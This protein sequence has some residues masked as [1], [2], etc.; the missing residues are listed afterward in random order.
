VVLLNGAAQGREQTSDR[1]LDSLQQRVADASRAARSNPLLD[2]NLIMNIPFT[3]GTPAVISHQLGRAYTSCFLLGQS[4]PGSIAVQRPCGTPG[5]GS[6]IALRTQVSRPLNAQNVL[7]TF[8][9]T[10]TPNFTGYADLWVF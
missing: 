1:Q 9:I 5:S 8:Q 7:D 2:G 3:S 6:S 4:A 10:V